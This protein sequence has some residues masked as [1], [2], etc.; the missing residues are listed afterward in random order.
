[1]MREI[2][3]QL[4]KQTIM[5]KAKKKK[6]K[7][8]R[9]TTKKWNERRKRTRKW[10][11]NKREQ[12]AIQYIDFIFSNFDDDVKDFNFDK[13][14]KISFSTREF[15]LLSVSQFQSSIVLVDSQLQIL[16]MNFQSQILQANFQ[17]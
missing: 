6:K 1:M 12:D 5:K 16:L 10:K 2:E 15:A 14:N 11:K 9:R 4:K 3:T 7:N 13:N 8:D 17:S